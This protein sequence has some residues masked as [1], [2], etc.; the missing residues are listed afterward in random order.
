MSP[1]AG[2][3]AFAAAKV[4]LCLHVGPRGADGYHSIASLMVFADVGD[5]V[6]LATADLRIDGEFADGL[7]AGPDNLVSKARAAFEAATRRPAPSLALDKALPIGAGLG[8]GSADA[9]AALRLL[10]AETEHPVARD[11]LEAIAGHLGA[12]VTACLQSLSVIAEGRGECL[13]AAPVMPPLD[14]VLVWPGAPSS[15]P[16]V[17]AAFDDMAPAGGS[18]ALP[19]MGASL[20]DLNA[21]LAFMGRTRNDLQAPAVALQP[22]IGEAIE[23][24]AREPEA[25][26][27]RMTGSGSAVFA[28]CRDAEA[29]TRTA[30]VVA[31]RHPRWWVRACRLGV[32]QAA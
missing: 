17:Y 15:T 7:S 30:D 6:R 16:A 21:V 10:N 32:P 5:R 26:F 27:V 28:I 25:L 19:P 20:A 18:L 1:T 24:L 8:G 14:A 29:A 3:S 11:A 2:R 13:T 12:D 31:E 9:A 22:V 23:A 4:N